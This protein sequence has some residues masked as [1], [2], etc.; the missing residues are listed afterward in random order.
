MMLGEASIRSTLD[1][2]EWPI[3]EFIVHAD[4]AIL[5][6]E[7]ETKYS[8]RRIRDRLS[9]SDLIKYVEAWGAPVSKFQFWTTESNSY[10]FAKKQE[11]LA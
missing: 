4:G 3:N 6:F 8:A 1:N 9:R 10:T 7:D 2:D 5:P 11:C